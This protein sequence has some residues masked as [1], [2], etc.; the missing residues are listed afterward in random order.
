M[1]PSYRL[2]TPLATSTNL[3]SLLQIDFTVFTSSKHNLNIQPSLK[4][5]VTTTIILKTY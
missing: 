1:Y 4:P 5:R 2:V 3:R